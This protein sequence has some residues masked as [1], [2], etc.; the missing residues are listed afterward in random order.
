M[1]PDQSDP[2]GLK[3]KMQSTN[4]LALGETESDLSDVPEDLSDCSEAQTLKRA[5]LEPTPVP[6]PLRTMRAT[7]TLH[8]ATPE[9]IATQELVR[10][11]SSRRSTRIAKTKGGLTDAAAV[12]VARPLEPINKTAKIATTRRSNVNT[13]RK[14]PLNRVAK[15]NKENKTKSSKIIAFKLSSPALEQVLGLSPTHEPFEQSRSASGVHR[16]NSVQ[17]VSSSENTSATVIPANLESLQPAPS[18]FQ[19]APVQVRRSTRTRTTCTHAQVSENAP[20]SSSISASMP[21]STP[22]RAPILQFPL[23]PDDTPQRE[24]VP[25]LDLP[26]L[27]WSN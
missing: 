20:L 12:H 10:A 4:G 2:N 23:T 13:T 17:Q 27:P 5:K 26:H 22:P 25:S 21:A 1:K 11:L 19:A 7:R 9:E 14:K 15:S 8:S 18:N 3:R 16:P 6:V 24:M